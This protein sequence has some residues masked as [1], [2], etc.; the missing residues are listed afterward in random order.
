MN[1]LKVTI[2]GTGFAGDYTAQVYSLIP[3]YRPGR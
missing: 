3:L 1:K 2:N